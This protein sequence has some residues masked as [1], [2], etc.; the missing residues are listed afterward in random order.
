MYIGKLSTLIDKSILVFP[1]DFS[2]EVSH[3][4]SLLYHLLSTDILIL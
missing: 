4:L 3:A 2:L 1:C